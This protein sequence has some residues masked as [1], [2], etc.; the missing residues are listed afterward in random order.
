MYNI[1]C[2]VTLHRN[3]QR[4]IHVPFFMPDEVLDSRAKLV[5]EGR[6]RHAMEAASSSIN[7]I[8][9]IGIVLTSDRSKRRMREK[10]I[11]FVGKH[12]DGLPF[13]VVRSY[14]LLLA[15]ARQVRAYKW[16]LSCY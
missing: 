1:M 14:A 15:A 10:T 2:V 3:A 9:K 11:P 12:L 6:L 8:I 16:Y 4:M 7:E 5:W 13:R